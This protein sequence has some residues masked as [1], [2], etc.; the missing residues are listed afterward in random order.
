MD[1][2]LTVT[3]ASVPLPRTEP[4]DFQSLSGPSAYTSECILSILRFWRWI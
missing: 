1:I 4:Y 2:S 3:R